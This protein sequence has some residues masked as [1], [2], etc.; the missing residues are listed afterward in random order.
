MHYKIGQHSKVDIILGYGTEL[1]ETNA[2]IQ[3]LNTLNE[4]DT[5]LILF[6][7]TS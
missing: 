6:R 7:K 4:K 5:W 1:Y 3:I 2:L